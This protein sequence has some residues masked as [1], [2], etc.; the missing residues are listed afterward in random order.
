M[1]VRDDRTVEQRERV[2]GRSETCFANAFCSLAD[3]RDPLSV[4]LVAVADRTVPG[5]A[6][7]NRIAPIR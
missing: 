7:A 6:L 1:A 2:G 4:H 3:D 5:Q